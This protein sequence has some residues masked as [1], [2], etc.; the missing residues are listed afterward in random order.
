MKSTS[1]R[2]FAALLLTSLLNA[3]IRLV[4]PRLSQDCTLA[5]GTQTCA[6]AAPAAPAK[7]AEGWYWGSGT[8]RANLAVDC[9]DSVSR[10]RKSD[11][12]HKHETSKTWTSVSFIPT[13]TSW[14]LNYVA[15]LYEERSPRRTCAQD[16]GVSARRGE[17]LG[18]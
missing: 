13:D 12:S 5:S 6:G 11:S 16:G 9:V 15:N 17:A 4:L 3:A 2:G 1:K 10:R 7:V 18:W 8:C 14:P